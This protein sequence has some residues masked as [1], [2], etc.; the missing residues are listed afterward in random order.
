MKLA[1]NFSTE[2]EIPRNRAVF[3]KSR[4]FVAFIDFDDY[5]TS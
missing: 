5:E 1:S 3:L 2:I 4:E